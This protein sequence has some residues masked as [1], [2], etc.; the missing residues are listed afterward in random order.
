[1]GEKNLGNMNFN[2]GNWVK[3]KGDLGYKSRE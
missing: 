3:W 1:M 2:G